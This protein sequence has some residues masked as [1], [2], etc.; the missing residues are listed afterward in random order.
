MLQDPL[1]N[2]IEET[3]KQQ[4]RFAEQHEDEKQVYHPQRYLLV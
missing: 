4:G 3:L 1:Y 2:L